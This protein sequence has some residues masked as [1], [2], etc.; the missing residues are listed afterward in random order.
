MGDIDDLPS[1][2]EPPEGEKPETE[3]R[4][5]FDRAIPDLLKRAVERAVETGVG[6]LSEGPDTLRHFVG[7]MKLPKEVLNYLYQQIDDTKT[8]LYRV[9]AKEIRDVLEHTQFADELTKVLTKLSFEIKTE[10]RFVPNDARSA[11]KTPAEESDA[12]ES[13][14]GES[15]AAEG[16][17]GLPKP[18]VSAQVTVKDRGKETRRERRR[19]EGT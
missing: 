4:R 13:E 8:G 15:A 5:T 18:S 17:K 3:R 2:E 19:R 9:V 12:E 7:D 14:E 11:E 16:Q 6:K 10:I 1:R